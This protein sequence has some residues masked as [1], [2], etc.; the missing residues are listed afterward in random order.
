LTNTLHLRPFGLNI[1]FKG[2]A[3]DD[4]NDIIDILT[5][6]VGF[7]TVANEPNLDLIDWVEN[8]LAKSGFRIQ[9]IPSPCGC[10][11]GLLAKFGDGDG[12]ILYSAHSDVVSTEGQDWTSDPF[13]LHRTG[14]RVIGRGTT[15]MKGF[16][17]CV[18]AQARS[19]RDMPPEKPFMIALSWDEEIG[20]RGIPNMID[21]VVPFLGC[22]D[23]VIVGE[24][25]EMQLCLG[26]KG[27]A[28]YQAICYGEAGHSAL[29]PNFKNALHVAA[30]FILATSDLQLR[31]AK[32][33]AR[34][35]AFTIPYSTLHAGIV[36]GGVALN[37]VP[38]RAEISFEIRHLTTEE[39][40]TILN[41]LDTP[42]E[43]MEIS[44]V[45]Q[46]PG[47]SANEADPIWKSVQALTNVPGPIKV[48]F[49]T[50]AGFFANIGLRTAVI[51]PGSMDCDGHK[52]D[53]G[54]DINQLRKCKDFCGK[55]Q[56]G[57]QSILSLN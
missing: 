35:D 32:S 55:L 6:L 13:V 24:P 40:A 4:L 37:I 9:R 26:H 16:L 51:G 8:F 54:I 20:C 49:G 3:L 48:A 34:D 10:K 11:A 19:C 29:A 25:T 42:S 28:S 27:K 30:R 57:L 50:E 1:N 45:Y 7:K 12:G 39:P 38:E 18:L 31:L 21:H 53:E 44:R 43:S 41:E 36:R 5:K 52:P 2:P 17:A 23:L 22:P 46:Y 15:D 14:G 33:G 56:H 47:L